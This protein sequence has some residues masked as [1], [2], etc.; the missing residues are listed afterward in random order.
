MIRAWVVDESAVPESVV[1]FVRREVEC[2]DNLSIINS[3]SDIVAMMLGFW[4]A[5][6]APVWVAIAVV[7]AVEAGLLLMIRDNLTLNI[8]MLIHPV[9]AIKRWQMG[10]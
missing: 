3:L 5:W 7:V 10:G 6:K 2:S 9:E 8:L 4:I 1:E